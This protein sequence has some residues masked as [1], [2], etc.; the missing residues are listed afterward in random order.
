MTRGHTGRA[1][2]GLML[3]V[4]L[5]ACSGGTG[6]DAGCDGSCG[7]AGDALS[8]ADVETV[9]AR[10][11][12]EADA[13]GV[14]ATVA[15]VDRVGNVLAV[16]QTNGAGGELVIRSPYGRSG[17]LENIAFLPATLSAI[18]K[19][20]TAAYL[21]SEGNAFSTRTASQIVQQF[22]NPGESGQPGGPLFG[23]QFSQL[24]CSDVVAT[25]AAGT[26]GPKRSPLGLS[27]DPGG[28]PLYRNGTVIGGVGVETDGVYTFDADVADRDDSDDEAVALAATA[29]LSAPGKRRAEY[30]TVD[31]KLLRYSDASGALTSGTPPP[32]AGLDGALVSVPG[33]F[34]ATGGVLAGTAFGTAASGIRADAGLFPGRD[35]FVLVD[36]SD[37]ERYAPQAGTD[38]V[39]ALSATEVQA[40]LDEAL[41]VAGQ[42]RA[43]IRRPLGTSARVSIAVTDRNGVLLGLVRSRD[44]PVF[45]IDVAVQKARTAAFFSG[46]SSAAELAALPPADYLEAELVLG[47]PVIAEQQSV[48]GYLPAFRDFIARPLALADGELAFSSR[49]V[50][51]LARPYYPDGIRGSDPGPLSKTF[52]DWSPFSTGLQLDLAYNRVT[53]HA[54]FAAGIAGSDIAAG[55]SGIVRSTGDGPVDPLA[56]GLQ[57]FPGGVP[58]Y[59]NGALVGAVG[60]SGDGV[61]QDDMIAFLAV[62][63]AGQHAGDFTNAPVPR[64]ADLLSP[65]GSHLRYVQC[66]QAPFRNSSRQDACAGR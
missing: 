49:A 32:F 38:G 34:S 56:N 9:V 42:A 64:R 4:W 11:V 1:M 59:R 50:G 20:V 44:A 27:A 25:T 12:A 28:F 40:I 3:G 35:A 5:V 21:S 63:R 41:G 2:A 47:L 65:Q 30:I 33:Y 8:V 17:G 7:T 52:P 66:P 26:P 55:C 6:S 45:G 31:G 46:T 16:Y 13:R 51:N 36:G 24:A 43:Q 15:V 53:G 23:V 54:A 58:V 60:V 10:A 37:S 57:I 48:A 22:F 61:D 18:S 29:G 19:A 39:D 62:D 14:E